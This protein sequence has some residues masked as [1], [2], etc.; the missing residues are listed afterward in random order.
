[1]PLGTAT[2]GLFPFRERYYS[3]ATTSTS[4][5]PASTVVVGNRCK[6]VSGWYAPNQIAGTGTNVTGFDVLS[7]T[8]ATSLS[9]GLVSIV[10]SG[11]SVTTSTGTLAVQWFP[12]NTT[13]LSAGDILVTI[14]STGVG[15]FVTHIV[16]EF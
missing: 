16:Q 11:V 4:G 15:G 3:V 13:F 14:G 9:S 7:I 12:T 6:Y 10:T 5:A 2:Q 8:A 1:M